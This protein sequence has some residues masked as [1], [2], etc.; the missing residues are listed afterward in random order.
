MN[1]KKLISEAKSTRDFKEDEVP[2]H[3][4]D[5]VVAYSKEGST[6]FPGEEIDMLVLNNGEVV[7]QS[8]QGIAGFNGIMIKAPAY[9]LF[10]S[11]KK[12]N[13]QINI[14]YYVQQ[15][16]LKLQQLGVDSCWITIPEDG[17]IIKAALKI[18]NNKEASALVAIGYDNNE[19]KVVNRFHFGENYSKA[20]MKVV[21]NNVATRLSMD[22]VIYINNWGNHVSVDELKDMGL[23]KVFH[24]AVMAPSSFNRQ[25]WRLLLKGDALHL[26]IRDDPGV[27]Y[28]LNLLDAG[29]FMYYIEI[30]MRDSNV[31]GK[32]HVETEF[33]IEEIPDNFKYIGFFMKS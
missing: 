32:W 13:H 7:N 12:E 16:L 24:Y 6:I 15:I 26:V 11:D 33:K 8:L 25:P 19:I 17:E 30:M 4:I 18:E 14:G 21:E 28:E 1:Y 23:D 27:N 22:K 31:L 9:L 10:F 20:N 29:I 3:V 5:E 2:S